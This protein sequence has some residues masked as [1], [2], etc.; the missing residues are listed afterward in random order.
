MG[1]LSDKFFAKGK[2]FLGVEYPVLCGAMA[3]VSEPKLV[4]SVCNAGGFGVLAGGSTPVQILADQIDKV[5]ELTDKPFAVNLITLTPEYPAHL[6]L[7]V[8][9]KPKFVVFAGGLPKN[10][11]IA[12]MKDAGIKVICFA[13]APVMA[14]RLVKAGADALIV[15]GKE[16]GGHIGLVATTVLV[17]EILFEYADKLPVFVAGGI[18]TSKFAAHMFMMGAAGVQLGT[19]FACSE[20]SHAHENFKNRFVKAQ[21]REA[22]ATSQFDSRLPIVGVRAIKNKGTDEFNKLQLE[23]VQK[24][25]DGEVTREFAQ[26]ELEKFW[27]GSLRKAVMDG[28]LE[29]GSLMAGQCVGLVKGVESVTDIV[30]DI[31]DGTEAELQRLK[32]LMA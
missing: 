26:E 2:E 14:K 15:E 31:V 9:K 23:M 7:M 12:M 32:T 11:E 18:A 17:Q 19:R 3:W 4:S 27:L 21:S 28:D 13:P 30:N 10:T 16:A 24:I 29:Y 20:E 6:E 1:N 22:G 25:V 8:E 5:R